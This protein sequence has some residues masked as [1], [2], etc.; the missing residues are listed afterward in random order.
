MSQKVYVLHRDGTPLMPTRPAKARH[1][2]GAG[3]AVVVR[4]DPFTIQLTEPSGKHVQ[5]VV[6]G[7]DMGA[8]KIGVAAVAAGQVLYQGEV[9]LRDD[10]SRRMNRRHMY[11][12]S[13]RSRKCRY[14]AP[15]FD[16]RRR[17]RGWLPP[18]I[19]SKVDSTVKVVQRIA[20]FLP[21]SLIRVEIAN[22]DTQAL[23]EGK[24]LAAWA[25]QQGELY[26][27]ENV[28]MYVRARD[29]YTCQYCGEE[30][31]GDLEVDHIVPRSRGGSNRPDNLVAACHE[32]NR[33]KGNQTV[34]E[35][36]HPEV[37]DRVKQSL[38][39]AAHVQAGKTATLERLAQVAPVETTYGYVTKVDRQM[40]GLPKTHFYDAVAIASG[41]EAITGLTTYEAMRAVSRGAY[42]QRRGAHSQLTARLPREVYGFRQWDVV[43]LPDGRACPERSRRVGFVKGRRS[44]GQFKISDLEGKVIKPSKTYR[45]LRLVRRAST[46]LTER[47]KVVGHNP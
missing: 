10:I 6:V 26:G 44:S 34:E 22:F 37:Q 27:W 16:N 7:V 4:R 8:K 36:G 41:G 5:P 32:C 47:R 1:L 21:V 3:K 35:Y 2:L 13:R 45:K 15:R 25:Y 20:S 17:P 33:E 46:L 18:S 28:K 30:H 23:R 11:R 40:M 43:E 39:A 14:R 29:N 24:R 12:R 38:R 19:Q 9:T 31:P 42:R